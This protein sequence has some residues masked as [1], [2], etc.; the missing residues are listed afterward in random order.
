[1]KIKLL[2]ISIPFLLMACKLGPL[3][4]GVT[5]TATAT[6]TATEN[7]IPT[8]APAST[9]TPS[10]APTFALIPTQVPPPTAIT[11]PKGTDL[12]RSTNTCYYATRTPKPQQ[13]FCADYKG[14]PGCVSHGCKWD[15]KTGSCS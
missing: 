10:G 13:N 9:E 8:A 14:K 6:A 15:A 3:L 1:M 5:P 2:L 7:V 11:C 12:N 4:L